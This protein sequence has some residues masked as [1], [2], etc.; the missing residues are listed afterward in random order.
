[1]NNFCRIQK[2]WLNQEDYMYDHWLWNYPRLL[3]T[4]FMISNLESVVFTS[5]G[6]E[7]AKNW[8]VS[9]LSWDAELGRS[10]FDGQRVV[11]CVQWFLFCSFSLMLVPKYFF[12]LIFAVC[13][14]SVAISGLHSPLLSWGVSDAYFDKVFN[15]L[16]IAFLFI[17]YILSLSL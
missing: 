11:K 10:V 6:F 1:M 14:P 7:K 2:R 15:W 13:V 5:F 3:C 17:I 12:P 4:F 8:N 16:L 9:I